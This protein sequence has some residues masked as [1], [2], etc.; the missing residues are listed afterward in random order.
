[1]RQ[2][3]ALDGLEAIRRGSAGARVLVVD[4]NAEMRSYLERLLREMGWNVESAADGDAALERARLSHPELVVADVMMPGSDGFELLRR[5]RAD[6]SLKSLPVVLVTARAAESAAVEGL[7]AGADDYIAKPFSARELA[8]RLGAQIQLARVRRRAERLDAYR[9]AL[10]DTLSPLSSPL[11]IEG[12]ACHVLREWLGAVRVCFGRLEPGGD[13][14]FSAWS[15][16][17]RAGRT[18][19]V[20]DAAT[21][22]A[23]DETQRREWAAL[24]VRSSVAIPLIQDGRTVAFTVVQS[25]DVRNWNDDDVLLVRETAERTW[26]ALERARAGADLRESEAALAKLNAACSRLWRMTTL[27]E[28]LDEMLAATMQLLGAQMGNVQLYR[29]GRGVLTIAV[30]R[31][32]AAGF[33]AHFAEVGAHDDSACGR[34]LRSGQRTLIEDVEQD[35][36]YAP[37]RDVARAAG[38]RSVQSTPLIGRSGPLGVIS[39]HWATPHR[40]TEHELRLLDLYARQAT[41]FMEWCHANERAGRSGVAIL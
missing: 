21:D 20:N 7:V 35:A 26:E 30:Q 22:P 17:L 14:E 36:A 3:A 15:D 28:G 13:R 40:C 39:T 37:L 2:P 32:F 6:A 34:A 27:E 38:Y 8:A 29:A 9:V 19:V 18:S 25:K 24:G 41:D 23:F 11:A 12:A 10:M 31:G 16:A 33:L 4:D 1:V 5:I